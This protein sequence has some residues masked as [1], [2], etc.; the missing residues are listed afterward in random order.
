[1]RS[2][3]LRSLTLGSLHLVEL[4]SQSADDQV[5]LTAIITGEGITDPVF[6]AAVHRLAAEPGL[7]RLRWS[8]V[9]DS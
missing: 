2:L 3:M 4:S 6:E 1:M 8:S 9:E 7:T 5:E